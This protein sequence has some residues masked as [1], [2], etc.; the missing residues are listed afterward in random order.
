MF[1]SDQSK[2]AINGASDRLL[3]KTELASRLRISRRTLDSWQRQGRVSYLKIGKS[4][5]YR[6]GDVIESLNRFRVN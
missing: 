3:T 1:I 4:C 2:Q 5:R 6:W